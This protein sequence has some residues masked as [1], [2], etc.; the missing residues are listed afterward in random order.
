SSLYYREW[1]KHNEN[2]TH[3]RWAWHNFF[4]EYDLL[5]TPMCVTG[6]FSHDHR[7]DF[8]QRAMTVN[9]E[10]RAYMEQLFWAGLTGVAYLPSTVFPTGPNA[11]GLPIGVQV[12]GPEMGDL[13]TIE[14]ARQVHAAQGGFVPPAD[15]R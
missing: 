12:V 1:H 14:F 6:A 9:N 2:R 13:R 3:L 5:L 10:R 8:E 4:K 7:P 11:Q 15:Y